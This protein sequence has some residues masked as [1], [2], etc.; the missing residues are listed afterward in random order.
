[1]KEKILILLASSF[2]AAITISL[3]ILS[4]SR[5]EAGIF[6]VAIVLGGIGGGFTLGL[7]GGERYGLKLPGKVGSDHKFDPGF[8]GDIF[9]GLMSSFL[10][11]GVASRTLKTDLFSTTEVSAIELW[12][13]NF[14]IAYICG[15]LGLR[16]IKGVSEKFLQEAQIKENSERLTKAEGTNAFLSAQTALSAGQFDEAE[17]LYH[18]AINLDKENEARARIR[19][20]ERRVGKECVQPCRSRWSPYH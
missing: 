18:K 2:S 1:M 16:F 3:V 20:E 11:I 8:L 6:F 7:I 17:N 12:F 5:V 10:G 9:V 13:V 19:S 4:N 14:S 15:F